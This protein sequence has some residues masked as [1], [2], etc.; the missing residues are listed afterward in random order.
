MTQ[1]KNTALAALLVLLPLVFACTQDETDLPAPFEPTAVLLELTLEHEG[2]AYPT[3][4]NGNSL[5]LSDSLPFDATEVVIKSLTL[6]PDASANRMAGDVLRVEDSPIAMMVTAAN[7]QASQ[8]YTLVLETGEEPDYAR[9]LFEA[10]TATS[11]GPFATIDIGAVRVENNVW[12]AGA[13][14]A[15]SY[16]QCIYSYENEDLELMGWQW[17][18]PDNANGVNAYPQLIYGHKPWQPSSTTQELPRK[19][20]DINT[21]KVTYDAEVTRNDGDYNLAFD[22]WINSE[23]SITPQ[24]I[25]FEFMIWEDVHQLVPFGDFQEEVTT[26]NGTYRFYSG[27]P[28]WEPPGSNWTYLA[29]QRTSNRTAG[30][31]D[32]DE[33]LAYLVNK[34]IVSPD[35]YL[36][37]I[38]LGTEVGNSTGSAVIKQFEVDIE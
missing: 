33:L 15:G 10:H 36:G 13:L 26:T 28:T 18:Y 6:S 20:A 30:T 34:G 5:T 12:N 2:V 1:R 35:S 16:T 4:I 11:C 17:E 7:G 24:N 38:E 21:L 9:L 29:F 22:N 27:E 3:E 8:V 25:V 31:V 14:P 23:A 32:I 37:S 19:I